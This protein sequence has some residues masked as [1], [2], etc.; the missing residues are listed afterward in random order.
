M[1][2]YWSDQSA[3]G[4]PDMQRDIR[5]ITLNVLASTVFKEKSEFIGSAHLKEKDLST[6]ESF[7]DAL[8]VVHYYIVHLMIIPYQYLT[9][10]YV[11]KSLY[12]IGYAARR[13][14]EV[15]KQVVK[16]EKIAIQDGKPGSG[17][18]VT[19]L[20]RAID[21]TSKRG[22]LTFDETLGN[23][24]MINFAGLDTTANVL[25]FTILRLAGEPELQ[26]WV[27][28]EI[29][30]VTQGR[31][32]EEW[33]YEVFPRLKRCFAVFLETL[34]MYPPVTAL[35]KMT[36]SG[37]QA[38]KVGDRSIEIPPGTDVFPMLLGVQTDPAYWKDPFT[39]KPSRWITHRE[40]SKGLDGEE[41]F[42]PQKGT[43][44]PWS[45]GAQNCLGKKISQVESVAVLSSLL[46]SHRV[47]I[48]AQAGETQDDIRR[49][50]ENCCD[51]NNYNVLLEMNDA[52]K[53]GLECVKR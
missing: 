26:D 39:W 8:F 44:F 31:P 52:A 49:R 22:V 1:R 2:E 42:E 11:P 18:L 47:L 37:V 27:L 12:K 36:V 34:R 4:I 29:I 48:K 53:V 25:A 23:I 43:F 40:D 38:V 51:D 17:G 32:V 50:I 5:T 45:D 9:G 28:E 7:R 14:K 46:A 6:A 15:M 21:H 3:A 41:L 24:F 16:E 13:L 30:S 19:S 20:V 33:D 10:P 35:P